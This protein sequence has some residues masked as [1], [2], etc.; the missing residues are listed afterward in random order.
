MTESQFWKGKTVDPPAGYRP[1]PPPRP[2]MRPLRPVIPIPPLRWGGRL[3]RRLRG[4]LAHSSSRTPLLPPRS[5]T[6]DAVGSIHPA[7]V[8]RILALCSDREQGEEP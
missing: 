5:W 4:L 8:A 3:W 7:D 2:P 1:V 6:T